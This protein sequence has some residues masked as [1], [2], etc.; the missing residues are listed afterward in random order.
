[1]KDYYA[2]LGIERDAPAEGVRTAYRKMAAAYHP[3]RNASPDAP[4]MFREAQE[5]YEILF[6]PE[7]RRA[8]DE[9]RRRS[10]VDDPLQTAVQ[11]WTTY[12]HKVL[13]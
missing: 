5:A 11:L 6:D 13:Q 3:D 4:A 12:L 10:L 2:I 9:S 8:Y 1:M 7:K